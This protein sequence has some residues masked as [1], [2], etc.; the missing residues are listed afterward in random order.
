MGNYKPQVTLEKGVVEGTLTTV[1]AGVVV[2]FLPQADPIEVASAIGLIIG[3][4]KMG[5]NWWKNRKGVPG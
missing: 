2:G 4:L 5:R 3:L 1:I